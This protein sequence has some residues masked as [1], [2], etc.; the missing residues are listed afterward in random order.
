MRVLREI[1]VVGERPASAEGAEAFRLALEQL[2]TTYIKLGQRLSSRPDLLPDVYIEELGRLVDE[3][4]PVPFAEIAPI[5]E[6]DLGPD[7]FVSIDEV[8]LATASIAQIHRAIL[9][10]GRDVVVKVRR[11]GIESQIEVDLELLR[12]TA[13]LAEGRSETARLLQVTA[14]AE[15]LETHL[16]GELDFDEDAHNPEIIARM[17]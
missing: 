7:T 12:S 10:D 3:V 4:P 13:A 5:V 14:L 8:P 2:G 9:K 17:L 6:A 1:G 15:E 16:R 11:P